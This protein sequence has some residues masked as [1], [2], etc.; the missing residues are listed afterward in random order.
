MLYY[1]RDNSVTFAPLP[2]SSTLCILSVAHSAVGWKNFC[3]RVG[4]LS[5][6]PVRSRIAGHCAFSTLLP[7]S[8][9][10]LYKRILKKDRTL[11]SRFAATFVLA[12]KT[13]CR[14]NTTTLASRR[15]G[16]RTYATR[17]TTSYLPARILPRTTRNRSSC[18]FIV[19]A[20]TWR[21]MPSY[22]G[23]QVRG[24]RYI[25]IIHISYFTSITV[26]CH[27]TRDAMV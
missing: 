13:C 21:T 15:A 1:R 3:L 20:G 18:L 22:P 8:S 9:R 16:R 10:V 27:L 26:A 24:F 4:S 19:P 5:D 23:T 7:Q 14:L 17:Y 12:R 2:P 6:L 11:R 25:F